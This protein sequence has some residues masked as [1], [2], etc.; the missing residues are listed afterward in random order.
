VTGRV[1]GRSILT[2]IAADRQ[3]EPTP[4]GRATIVPAPHDVPQGSDLACDEC[5]AIPQLVEQQRNGY[6]HFERVHSLVL[7][8]SYACETCHAELVP[9]IAERHTRL[10]PVLQVD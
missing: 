4:P 3:L 7:E 6:A 9:Y 10:V 1:A 2:A 5:H 8:R